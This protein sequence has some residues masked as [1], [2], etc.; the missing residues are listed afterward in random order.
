MNENMAHKFIKRFFLI[1]AA[2]LVISA[3]IVYLFDPFYHYHKPWFSLKAVLTE[4]EYQVVGT[5]RNFDYDALIV[6]SSV[7]ENNNNA[8][9]SEDF[10]C[11]AIKAVRSYG[12]TADLCYLL[13]IAYESHDVKK[14]FYCIDTSSLIKDTTITFESSGAPMYLYDTNIFNDYLYLLNKDVIFEKIP[15]MIVKSLSSDY[16]ENL[17]YNWEEG[18]IFEESAMLSHYARS[19]SIDEMKDENYYEENLYAN[20][21]LLK[22]EIENHPET[23]FTFFFPVYSMMFWDSAYRS[24][25]LDAYIYNEKI[26]METLLSYN[27]VSVYFFQ[28]DEEIATN[29]N[30]YMDNV[31]FSSEINHYMEQAMLN[32]EY[33]VTTENLDVVIDDM[34]EFC[35]K[36]VNEY[37]KYYEENDMFTYDVAY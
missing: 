11:T 12:A 19:S 18:K 24:G 30:N 3:M 4:K 35:E 31:H 34:K 20:I 10:D 5:L 9:F 14:V 29:L 1:T 36:I 21:E 15:Y 32:G 33:K 25:D 23:E 13:D 6:G 28:N 16:D 37:V 7:T 8:W 22:T 27:N 2:L 26:A 17:S